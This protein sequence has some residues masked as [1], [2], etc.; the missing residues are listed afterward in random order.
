MSTINR[1]WV[2]VSVQVLRVMKMKMFWKRRW[3]LLLSKKFDTEYG[4]TVPYFA[5]PFTFLNTKEEN[6]VATNLAIGSEYHPNGW[7]YG[8]V[9]AEVGFDL[10]K[11]YSYISVFA[12]FPLIAKKDSGN[13]LCCLGFLRMRPELLQIFM[14][15]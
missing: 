4:L 15:I 7:E 5:V 1:R 11:S 12:T 3:L 13:N 6:L 10:N 2:F 8:T 9:G 14:S